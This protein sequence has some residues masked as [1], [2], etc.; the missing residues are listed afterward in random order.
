[1]AIR[2]PRCGRE[3]DVTMF[4]FGREVICSCGRR[5]T[6][7]QRQDLIEYP[8]LDALEKEIFREADRKERRRDWE[9]MEMIRRRADRIT[10]QILYSD[11]PRVDVEIAIRAFREE[12]MSHFPRKRDLFDGIYL[13]R[14]RRLWKQFRNPDETILAEEDF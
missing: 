14:F 13:L 3:F 2:C 4:E 9:R 8:G 11:L 6:L 7:E 1:M 5:I 10:I 12:V